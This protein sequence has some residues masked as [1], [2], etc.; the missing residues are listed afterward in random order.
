M[1]RVLLAGDGMK[2]SRKALRF[3]VDLCKALKVSLSVVQVIDYSQYGKYLKK[4]RNSSVRVRCLFE[5]SMMAATFAEAGEHDTGS[6]LM[7]LARKN[8]TDLLREFEGSGIQYSLDVKFG[9]PSREIVSYVSQHREVAV[10]IYD[11]SA[12]DNGEPDRSFAKQTFKR[13]KE[14]VSVPLVVMHA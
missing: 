4:L 3:A 11:A 1:E 9:E 10:A 6:E 2:P 12:E 5:G 7:A 8:A 14:R 13:I